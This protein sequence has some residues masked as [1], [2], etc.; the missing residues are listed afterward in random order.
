[1]IAF[2]APPLCPSCGTYVQPRIPA[3]PHMMGFFDG[4]KGAFDN[5]PRLEKDRNVNAGK[6]KQVPE[7]VKRKQAERKSGTPQQQNDEGKT[8][9]RT[10]EELFSGWKW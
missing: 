1:M 6:S 8:G 10:I 9:D 5:D 3:E 7:Y 4:L 2:V